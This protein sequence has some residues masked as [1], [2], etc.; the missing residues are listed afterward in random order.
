MTTILK[1]CVFGSEST[2]KSTLARGLADHF[3]TCH[4]PE[5][6]RELIAE[7]DGA[8]SL[9]DIDRIA[10]GQMAAEDRMLHRAN[11]LLVCDTDLMTTAIWS[12]WLFGSCPEWIKAEAAR[13]QYNLYLLTDIDVPWVDDIHRYLPEDRAAF[14]ARCEKELVDR[15][16]NYVKIQGSWQQRFETACKAVNI[17]L[18]GT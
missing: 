8:L 3:Q 5:Y 16:I 1:V 2:G 11:R 6:A 15:G 10:R 13:R 7:Q 14:Q 4:V 18:S 12:E 17:L 9:A